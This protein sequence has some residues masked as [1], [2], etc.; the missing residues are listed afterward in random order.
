M[1]GGALGRAVGANLPGRARAHAQLLLVPFVAVESVR[2][3]DGVDEFSHD[4]RVARQKAPSDGIRER[5][6]VGD[7]SEHLGGT[8]QG[9]GMCLAV[10]AF[11]K[12]SDG[13]S[14]MA[15]AWSARTSTPPSEAT[16]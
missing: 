14:L 3:Y 2:G 15:G 12:P 1:A 11:S 13:R 5:Q 8:E 16:S 7:R 4:D 6:F 10:V 9:G